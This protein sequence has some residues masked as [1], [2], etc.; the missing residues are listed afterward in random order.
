MPRAFEP[1]NLKAAPAVVRAYF[2][3]R[4][5]CID[6]AWRDPADPAWAAFTRA[7]QEF[8]AFL[9]GQGGS[10]QF[11]GVTFKLEQNRG[12]SIEQESAPGSREGTPGVEPA[13]AA[14]ASAGG[15]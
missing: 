12:I 1:A 14:A 3:T 11:G 15:D 2:E 6:H 13:S 9:K 4:R 7:S 5:V 10:W 8:S